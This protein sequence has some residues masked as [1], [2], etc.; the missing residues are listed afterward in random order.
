MGR[1]GNGDLLVRRFSC[2]QGFKPVTVK[3]VTQNSEARLAEQ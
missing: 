3:K 2:G 1:Q